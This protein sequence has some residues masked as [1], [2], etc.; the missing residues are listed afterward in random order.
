MS[1]SDESN[2]DRLLLSDGRWLTYRRWGLLGGRPLLWIGGNPGSRLSRHPDPAFYDRHGLDAVTFDRPGYGRSTRRPGRRVADTAGDVREL[3]DALDWSRCEIV[4]LSGG[5]AHA[6]AS[7]ALLAERISAVAVVGSPSPPAGTPGWEANLLADN[8]R[9]LELVRHDRDGLDDHLRISAE[10]I[11][12]EPLAVIAG[13][14][15]ETPEPDIAFLQRPDMVAMLTESL[16]EAFAVSH[17]GWFDDTVAINTDWGF[18]L[19]T[20]GVPVLIL[21]GAL[22]R[23]APVSQARAL[24]EVLPR[25]HL[26]IWPDLGH[27][28]ALSRLDEVVGELSKMKP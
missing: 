3:I 22:D 8:R 11:V 28:S 23:N 16:S 19:E 17:H 5:G 24:S 20:V 26:T 12:D 13:M 9:S 15:E 10:R 1:G 21:Q 7:G 25:A 2:V 14:M 6:L 27:I 4:G 18:D